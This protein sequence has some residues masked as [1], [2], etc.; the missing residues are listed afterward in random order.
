MNERDLELDD[1]IRGRSHKSEPVL[2]FQLT[3]SKREC[4][5]LTS[6]KGNCKKDNFHITV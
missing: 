3:P 1:D 2:I 5:N 4:Y 6:P